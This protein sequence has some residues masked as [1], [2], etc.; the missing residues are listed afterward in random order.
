VTTRRGGVLRRALATRDGRVALAL[1]GTLTFLSFILP[2]FLAA[3]NASDFS[4]P[5]AADGGPPTPTVAHPLG[6]DP[7]YR[8]VLSRLAAGGRVSLLCAGAAALLAS[9]IGLA[10][11]VGAA[12]AARSGARWADSLLMRLVDVLLAMPFLLVITTI[13]VLVGRTDATTLVLVMG[14]TGWTG[15]ARVVRSRALAILSQDFVLS[16]RALGGDVLF[17]A[18]RHVLPNV[19]PVAI[20][21]GTSLVGSM[22]L[23]EAVLGYL[24]VGIEPPQATWGRMLHEAESLVVLRP[25]LVASPGACIIGAMLGLHRLG[26]A[27][28]IVTSTSRQDD[29]PG[30][31]PVDVLVASAALVL[32]VALPTKELAPP[33]EAGLAE[34]PVEGGVLHLATLYTVRTLDP[35]TAPE[36]ISIALAR[37]VFDRL[38]T[39]DADGNVAPSLAERWSWSEGGKALEVELR[40]GVVFQDG[41]P[42]TA[43]DVKRSIE[44]A[45]HP[46][47]A[48]PGASMFA[49]LEGF[50]A[51]RSGSA[52]ELTGV[53][54]SGE[55]RVIFRLKEP[56]AT[57]PSLLTLSYVAPVCPS[58][59]A[60]PE[61]TEATLCGAGPFKIARFEPEYGV[62]LERNHT[63]HRPGVLLDAIELDFL[64][65][66]QAQRYRFERGEIELTRELSG[67]DAMLV[68]A[69]PRWAP[70]T[71]LVPSLRVNAIFL[72]TEVPPFDN[73]D[74][75]RAVSFAIDPSVVARLRPE[76]M[77][78]SRV[79]PDAVP[80][81]RTPALERRHDLAAALESMA[82]A[83]YAFDP[84]TGTGG[85][86]EPIDYLTIPDTFEQP[87][88]EV[89][90]QQLARIG[91]RIRLRLLSHQSYLS[92]V[93]RRGRSPMGWAGWQADY[94]DPLTF[95][96]PKLVSRSIGPVSLNNSFYSSPELDALVER[97]RTE[98][99]PASRDALFSRAEEIVARDAP[100]IPV[101]TSRVIELRQPWLRGYKSTALAQLDFAHAWLARPS[102]DE[103]QARAALGM[104]PF[105]GS[106]PFQ[107]SRP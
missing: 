92:E 44:R 87:T 28:R 23:A 63:H 36:E 33:D 47:A 40:H 65:R 31:V 41:S 22:I 79:V 82:R 67:A 32:L 7:L 2:L 86:P 103:R 88:A 57:L 35:A 37:L 72:N 81:H 80:G 66:P 54:V 15:L 20:V 105:F 53:T 6:T 51:Y 4:L 78:L 16:S 13:G 95:F 55:H 48:S 46:R 24:A 83:G 3:P 9:L 49:N 18:L 89:Y 97:G 58:V 85:Y 52:I 27:L 77:A 84:A 106:A 62:R 74:I 26:E 30:R 14:L 94:P 5:A 60:V 59:P 71:N 61:T 25:L 76:V 45:L 75:R 17:V 70:Y 98:T 104:A 56:D 64:V 34:E 12:T 21:L 42:L 99:D 68:R 29:R 19:A 38:L 93:Q 50:E 91:I 73:P 90:Q 101:T 10:V 39:F 43:A 8:D 69:D 100:W 96:D 1:L 107:G 102:A 11:G